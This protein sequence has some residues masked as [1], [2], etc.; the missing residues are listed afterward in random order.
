M[1]PS[2]ISLS[3]YRQKLCLTTQG[4][5]RQPAFEADIPDPVTSEDIPG[6]G[7]TSDSGDTQNSGNSPSSGDQSTQPPTTLSDPAGNTLALSQTV[8]TSATDLH[9][10]IFVHGPSGVYG[11]L[12]KTWKTP[13]NKKMNEFSNA[14]LGEYLI[15]IEANVKCPM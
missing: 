14:E 3:T 1:S 4:G 10:T 6:S 11:E 8:G 5:L 7:D 9:R 15:G 2:K 13:G 12:P